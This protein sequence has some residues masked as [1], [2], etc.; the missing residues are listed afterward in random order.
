MAPRRARPAAETDAPASEV[1]VRLY[2]LADA[3]EGKARDD[4][5]GD[6]DDDDDDDDDA[7]T[8]DPVRLPGTG[9][10]DAAASATMSRIA[11]VA[12]RALDPLDAH[13]VDDSDSDGYS[14]SSDADRSDVDDPVADATMERIFATSRATPHDDAHDRSCD[15][16]KNEEHVTR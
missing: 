6:D 16:R 7:L 5:G 13:E 4:D 9:E 11:R 8:A 1:D 12:S 10:I 2:T 14:S 15:T 3:E